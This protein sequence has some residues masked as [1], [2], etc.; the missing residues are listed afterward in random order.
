MKKNMRRHL[1]EWSTGL[2]SKLQALPPPIR[3]QACVRLGD[4]VWGAIRLEVRARALVWLGDF[5]WGM[6]KAHLLK[7]FPSSPPPEPT[8]NALAE[9][10]PRW[11]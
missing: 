11:N 4:A 3:S 7:L 8:P 1:P 5:A 6:I 10:N 2:P 9:V